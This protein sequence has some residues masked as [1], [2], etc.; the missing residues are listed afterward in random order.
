MSRTHPDK[1]NF[2]HSS[3]VS[4]VGQGIDSFSS[5]LLSPDVQ[6]LDVSGTKIE[7]FEG[8]GIRGKLT[9]LKA[10]RTRI[11]S[12]RGAEP[13]QA[14]QTLL[15]LQTPIADARHLELMSAV[16][17]GSSLRTVNGT[18]VQQKT[19]ALANQLRPNVL[20]YLSEGY[21]L[22]ATSP[23]TIGKPGSSDAIIVDLTEQQYLEKRRQSEENERKLAEMRER[24]AQLHREQTRRPPPK[25]PLPHPPPKKPT[26]PEPSARLRK[27]RKPPKAPSEPAPDAQ[28]SIEPIPSEQIAEPPLVNREASASIPPVAGPPIES[29]NPTIALIPGNAPPEAVAPPPIEPT[30]EADVEIAEPEAGPEPQ[31][32]LDAAFGASCK[33]QIPPKSDEEE[34]TKEDGLPVGQASMDMTDSLTASTDGLEVSPAQDV[35]RSGGDREFVVKQIPII[36]TGFSDSDDQMA[37]LDADSPT[38]PEPQQRP[39][40]PPANRRSVDCELEMIRALHVAVVDESRIPDEN[41]DSFDG[42]SSIAPVIKLDANLSSDD[43]LADD[44]DPRSSKK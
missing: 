36:E 38:K 27:P 4:V 21:L 12:F 37:R 39:G 3:F 15:L 24:L 17:F 8:L 33:Q 5:I 35:P 13:Q 44:L 14:L 2:G 40:K 9:S 31:S 43:L 6:A 34:E 42:L 11:Q 7:D 22:L 30:A 16:I 1:R 19:H 29:T 23:L 28:T 25:A 41:S 20:R 18:L 32:D 26:P 10:D